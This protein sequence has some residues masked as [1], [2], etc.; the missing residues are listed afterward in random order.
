MA[1]RLP[2]VLKEVGLVAELDSM[3]LTSTI[4]TIDSNT[5]FGV[6]DYIINI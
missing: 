4:K 5:T 1:Q 6:T 3:Q 2:I